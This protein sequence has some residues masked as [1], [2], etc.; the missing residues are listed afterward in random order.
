MKIFMLIFDISVNLSQNIQQVFADR[1]LRKKSKNGNFTFQVGDGMR[2]WSVKWTC[3]TSCCKLST[4]W[5]AFVRDN[6]LQVGDVCVFEL[7]NADKSLFNV[8]IFRAA[9][10]V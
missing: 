2:V 6:Y 8:V 9:E 10:A 7:I 1:Y 5:G 3:F 4:G